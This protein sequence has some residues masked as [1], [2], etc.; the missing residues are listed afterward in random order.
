MFPQLRLQADKLREEFTEFQLTDRKDLPQ[1]DS[2]DQF[3]GLL[4]K[5]RYSELPRLM[6]ALLSI[7]HSNASSERV[8][9][10]VRK[11]VTENRMSLD[12][13]TV[14]A[15]LSCKINYSGPVHK[16]TPSKTVLRNAK[17]ATNLYNKSLKE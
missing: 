15:L 14:S 3:W 5:D 13:T 17:S 9:S 1:E 8:F 16:Y 4:G 7:P 10:M 2:I 11:I 12:N 6:K